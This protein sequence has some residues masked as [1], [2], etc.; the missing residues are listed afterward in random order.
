MEDGVKREVRVTFVGARGLRW[1]SKRADEDHWTYD[2]PP[3]REDWDGLI[4]RME[5]R[6]RRRSVSWKLLE[7]AKRRRSEALS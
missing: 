5:F 7:M 2:F 6:Y 4:E 3:T 1:Q